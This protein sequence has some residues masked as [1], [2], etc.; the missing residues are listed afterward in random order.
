MM[1]AP[2]STV[3]MIASARSWGDALGT[4]LSSPAAS[5]KIGRKRRLHASYKCSV[6]ACEAVAAG[7][8][9]SQLPG[10]LAD[11]LAGKLRMREENGPVD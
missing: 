9:S 10:D 3:S 11:M 2:A 8:E 5:E 7:T 4:T 1:R 6:H